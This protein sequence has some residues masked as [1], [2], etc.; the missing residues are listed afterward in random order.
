MTMQT[1]FGAT[2][3]GLRF[4]A[5][6]FARAFR[7]SLRSLFE[8]SGPATHPAE[9]GGAQPRPAKSEGRA[10]PERRKAK[11]AGRSADRRTVLAGIAAALLLASLPGCFSLGRDSP[12]LEQYVLGG[13][14]LLDTM[15]PIA[16]L[17]GIAVGLRRIDLAPYIASPAI[18]VRRGTHE[19]VTSD[20]HRW[21]EDPADGIS[22]AVARHLA[23]AASFLA[24]DVAPWPVRSRYDY[25]IQLR[26]TRFEGVVPAEPSATEG[27]V[28]V[29]AS[30]EIIRQL[31]ET[32]LARGLTEHRESGWSVGDYAGLVALL[33]R[34]LAVLAHEVAAAIGGLE[35]VGSA[36]EVGRRP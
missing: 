5:P 15:A 23:D 30:W 26:V 6:R 25:L 10:A 29:R 16:G 35:A 8:G 14:G 3:F 34:G 32:V 36:A 19:V 27:A 7:R 22:R 1:M 33:N 31:D 18:V 13:A 21:G 17:D 4:S 28:L 11:P 12:E 20:F 2:P 9:K 24:V